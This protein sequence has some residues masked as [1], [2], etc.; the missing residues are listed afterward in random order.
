M[1]LLK[2]CFAKAIGWA[3]KS[4]NPSKGKRFISSSKCQ[5]WLYGPPQPPIQQVPGTLSPRVQW[6]GYDADHSSKTRTNIKDEWSY[7]SSSLYAFIACIDSV[8]LSN[9]TK[10]VILKNFF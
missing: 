10:L 5:D 8:L 3:I 1:N 4:C 6:P 9:T 7:Y 2:N